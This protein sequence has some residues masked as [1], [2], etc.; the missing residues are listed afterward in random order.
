MFYIASFAIGLGPVFWLLI[1]EIYPLAVRGTAM[2]LAAVANWAANWLVSVTF[3][4]LV[5]AFGQSG[6]FL[7]YAVIGV[8]A[9]FFCQRL[10]PETKGKTLE[11]IEAYFRSR[12]DRGHPQSGVSPSTSAIT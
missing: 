9:W 1:A 12:S 10:V 3:L 6:T 5:A 7:L 4:G 8:A 2:S 11:D